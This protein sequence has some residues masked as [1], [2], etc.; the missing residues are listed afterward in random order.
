[1]DGP[2]IDA[3]RLRRERRE[4]CLEA[5]RAHGIDA[6]VLGR[7]ANVT[8]V[9]GGE[10]LWV[11]GTRPFAPAAVV[12][13]ADA[14]VHLIAMSADGVPDDVARD[15]VHF[16][17]WDGE[18]LARTL[19]DV[20]G[21]R[22]ARRIGSDGMTPRWAASL[23][24]ALPRAELADGEAAMRDARRVK[25]GDEIACIRRAI[26][27]AETA[28]AAAARA[29][30]PGV[31]ERELRARFVEVAAESGATALA[32]PIAI[33]V[34]DVA[35]LSAGVLH[36]GYE[37]TLARTWPCLT[38]PADSDELRALRDRWRRAFDRLATACRAG[39]TLADVR[40][41]CSAAAR[42]AGGHAAVRGVGLGVEPPVVT[43]AEDGGGEDETLAAGMVLAVEVAA[44]ATDERRY[45][46][47][48]VV[49]VGPE[50]VELLTRL[51]HDPVALT[52]GRSGSA[53]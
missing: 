37:G 8:Y 25:T 47:R 44:H 33:A 41:A 5:A 34:G 50:G 10:R 46:A 14:A 39:A 27:I 32:T 24:A 49:V 29:I 23:A 38:A 52:R 45:L 35:A 22:A 17:T 9:T 42:E 4:R 2:A 53:G 7:E 6:V 51:P 12:V 36:H 40:A 21:L 20:P 48:E 31:T 15:R 3:E 11:A 18:R 28:L 43:A 19:A 30:R 16:T 1:V 26:A 13:V